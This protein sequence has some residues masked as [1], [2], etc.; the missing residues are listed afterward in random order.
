MKTGLNATLDPT[1]RSSDALEFE[2]SLRRKIVGQDPAV[3]KVAEIY[4]MFLAGL[5]LRDGQLE[6]CFFWGQPVPARR[7]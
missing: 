5:N 4:Q 1:L 3:E 7:A 2:T 6:I